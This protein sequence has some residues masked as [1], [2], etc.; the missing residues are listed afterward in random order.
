MAPPP[1]EVVITRATAESRALRRALRAAGFAPVSL[2]ALALRPEPAMSAAALAQRLARLDALVALSPAAVRFARLLLPRPA[3]PAGV[4]RL[5]VGAASARALA[6]W[7]GGPV[8]HGRP[9]GSEG[10]LALPELAEPAGM[11]V[12]LLGAPGGRELIAETLAAR[13][14]GVE[15]IPVYRRDRARWD[16]RHRARLAALERPLVLLSSVEALR[17][18]LDLAGADRHR[19][20]SGTAVVSSARLARQAGEAGFARVLLAGGPHPRDWLRALCGEGRPAT[21][22]GGS[23][24][25][26]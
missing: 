6:R 5:A 9:P 13:G 15:P 2:P 17:A 26:R 23:G 12:G 18:L 7:A 1:A 22:P 3:L 10:L 8:R 4:L 16:R 25:R 24:T 14:A 19:L 20:L 11:R 21:M